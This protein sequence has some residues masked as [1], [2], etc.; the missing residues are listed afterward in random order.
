M[1]KIISFV[2]CVLPLWVMSQT[3]LDT[4]F[5]RNNPFKGEEWWW[6][7]AGLGDP[8]E[9]DSLGKKY[10]FKLITSLRSA[11]PTSAQLTTIDS[12]Y[13]PFA[14][15]FFRDYWRSPDARDNMG[16]GIDTKLRL[17]PP[18]APYIARAD[19]VRNAGFESRKSN[20]RQISRSQN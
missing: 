11:N 13:G 4:V 20:G 6:G 1:K 3:R 12:L 9:M 2:C 10:Y 5:V 7:V 18:L 19:S 17:Y 8:L 14:M 16:Q 15:K